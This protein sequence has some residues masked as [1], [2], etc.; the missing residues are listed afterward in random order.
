MNHVNNSML[1]N[2]LHVL[3]I[4]II[5]ANLYNIKVAKKWETA[6]QK[7]IID[8]QKTICSANNR[9]NVHRY[10]ISLHQYYRK[11]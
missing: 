8:L 9:K 4:N 3:I 2:V 1:T 5:G 10:A 7:C 6:E 11:G